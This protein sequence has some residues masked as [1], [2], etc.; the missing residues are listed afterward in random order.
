MNINI[1]LLSKSIASTKLKNADKINIRELEEE[2]KNNFIAFADDG[3]NS[4][5]VNVRIDEAGEV[6]ELTCDCESKVICIHK[7]A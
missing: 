3:D 7:I 1:H 6:Q 5:D 2:G 4:F